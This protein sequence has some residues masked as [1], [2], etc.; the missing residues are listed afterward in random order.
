MSID[1]D[2]YNDEEAVIHNALYFGSTAQKTIATHG[3]LTLSQMIKSASPIEMRMKHCST[4][5]QRC[6][7]DNANDRRR[8]HPC[9]RQEEE[10]GR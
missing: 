10:G 6:E 1:T 5:G 9:Q 2:Q 4:C 7:R 8:C 3:V